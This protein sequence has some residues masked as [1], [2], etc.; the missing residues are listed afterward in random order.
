MSGRLLR[1]GE[2]CRLTGL[3][4]SS[5]YRQIAAGEFVPR[6]RVSQRAIAFEEA[7]V[8]A[9]IATRVRI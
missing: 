8:H 2:V 6:V 1:L 5:I 4:R 7:A 9:W 3:S